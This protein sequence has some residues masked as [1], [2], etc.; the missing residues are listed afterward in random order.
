MAMRCR[1]YVWMLLPYT[2]Y[3]LCFMMGRRAFRCTVQWQFFFT[4]LSEKIRYVILNESYYYCHAI[5]IFCWMDYFSKGLN[6]ENLIQNLTIVHGWLDVST[7]NVGLH[8]TLFR[9]SFILYLDITLVS[10]KS[11]IYYTSLLWKKLLKIVF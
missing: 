11:L 2:W 6:T 3:L 5:K 10:V 8:L 1:K 7:P 9:H 4:F